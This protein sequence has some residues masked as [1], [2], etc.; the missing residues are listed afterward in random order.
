MAAQVPLGP[1]VPDRG[2]RGCGLTFWLATADLN[3]QHPLGSGVLIGAG[4]A[5]TAFSVL[6]AA[7]WKKPNFAMNVG[8]G[9]VIIGLGLTE[10]RYTTATFMLLLV[11]LATPPIMRSGHWVLAA[12]RARR[13][14]Q[15]PDSGLADV[16]RW[17]DNALDGTPAR[18]YGD[19]R[20]GT[21]AAGWPDGPDE[22]EQPNR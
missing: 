19:P 13:A 2:D 10:S 6:S 3:G 17:P 21:P 16:A 8:T 1:G 12:I 11:V 5:V 9:L 14:S 18:E 4:S 22:A 20:A 15:Q 7:R